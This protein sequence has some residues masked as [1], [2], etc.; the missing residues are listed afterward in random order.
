[1]DLKLKGITWVGN[2]Y[3]RFEEI[4]QEVDDV[5]SQ[6]AVK[7]VENQVQNVGESV[8]K[9]YSDVVHD[10]LPPFADPAKHE[11]QTVPSKRNTAEIRSLFKPIIG[12]KENK[13]EIEENPVKTVIKPSCESSAFDFA[14]NQL[15]HVPS[16][17]HLVTQS[18]SWTSSNSFELEEFD[19]ALEKVGDDY[20][21][22]NSPVSVEQ[23]VLKFTPQVLDLVSPCHEELS[24]AS[25]FSKSFDGFDNNSF[26]AGTKVNSDVSAEENSHLIDEDNATKKST[27]LVIELISPVNKGPHEGA[28]ISGSFSDF[29][30]KACGD[31]AGTK[32]DTDVGVD[33]SDVRVEESSYVIDEENGMGMSNS[34]M[35]ELISFDEKESSGASNF[36]GS[37]DVGAENACGVASAVSDATSIQNMELLSSQKMGTVTDNFADETECIFDSLDTLSSSKMAFS[38]MSSQISS[39]KME[40]LSLNCSLC[41]GSQC[42]NSSENFSS[43]AVSCKNNLAAVTGCTS[44]STRLLVCS[45]PAS[46][47]DGEIM[48]FEATHVSSCRSQSVESCDDSICNSIIFGMENVELYNKSKLEESCVFVD[49]SELHAVSCRARKLRS[50]KKRIQ[51]AFSSKKRLTKEYEQLAIWYGDTDMEFSQDRSHS[52]FPITPRTSLESKK[53]EGQHACDSEWE[54][55]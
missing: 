48:E 34:E 49:D 4:C 17:D 37:V 31:L 52:L 13:E 35:L 20:T 21:K 8:K 18:G 46:D 7:Y 1:M 41:W 28:F 22:E 14:N 55:L 53:L 23:D 5:V 9:I 19:L 6:D 10:L 2:I 27:P 45:A 42:A 36:T 39:T 40:P 47:A 16:G 11:A 3:Q 33:Y 12:N 38:S 50:Y 44:Y 25:H 26:G 15:S 54:L 30:E 51:D 24:E 29:N 43:E 32:K